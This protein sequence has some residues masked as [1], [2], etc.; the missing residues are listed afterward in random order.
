MVPA[1]VVERVDPDARTVYLRVSKDDVKNAPD[2]DPDRQ[3]EDERSAVDAHYGTAA[4]RP[5]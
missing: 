2:Y 5:T 4:G 3:F 1:G